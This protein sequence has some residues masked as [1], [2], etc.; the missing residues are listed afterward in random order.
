MLEE[1][2]PLHWQL[3]L[4]K[5]LEASWEKRGWHLPHLPRKWKGMK[6]DRI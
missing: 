5:E 3:H 6:M 4:E 2:A 1:L